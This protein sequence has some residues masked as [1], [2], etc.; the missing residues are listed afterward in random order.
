MVFSKKL[1]RVKGTRDFTGDR[2]R[3]DDLHQPTESFDSRMLDRQRRGD[4]T[5]LDRDLAASIMAQTLRCLAVCPARQADQLVSS[6]RGIRHCLIVGSLLLVES[7]A[8]DPA[9][10]PSSCLDLKR[11]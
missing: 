1:I 5:A 6:A 11:C 7:S 9:G 8:P 2:D 4:W 3:P 10:D